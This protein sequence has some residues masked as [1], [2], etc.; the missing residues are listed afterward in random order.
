MNEILCIFSIEYKGL[1]NK[2]WYLKILFCFSMCYIVF[3][4]SCSKT[5]R[6]VV[7][8]TANNVKKP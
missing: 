7:S 1:Q 6:E 5:L 4:Q 2:K 3:E 8:N